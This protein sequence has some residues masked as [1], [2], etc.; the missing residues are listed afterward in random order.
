MTDRPGPDAEGQRV[1]RVPGAR[2]ARLTPVPGTDP[3]PD[4]APDVRA[5]PESGRRRGPKG[6]NDDRLIQDVPP[7]Y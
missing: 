7:H 1:V 5:E 6:P 2:R 3:E 4:S